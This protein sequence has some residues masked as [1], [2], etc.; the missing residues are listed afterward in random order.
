MASS[1][2]Q[3]CEAV[4]RHLFDIKY[5]GFNP[6]DNMQQSQILQSSS[7]QVSHDFPPQQQSHQL[8]L[9]HPFP[10]DSKSSVA[11]Q[12]TIIQQDSLSNIP[13]KNDIQSPISIQNSIPS[14][15]IQ[16]PNPTLQNYQ[17]QQP[18]SLVP[19]SNLGLQLK[20][21]ESNTPKLKSRKSLQIPGLSL[22][23]TRSVVGSQDILKTNR[24]GNSSII[25]SVNSTAAS[26]TLISSKS[27]KISVSPASSIQIQASKTSPLFE[28]QN[29]INARKNGSVK[30]NEQFSK[31][32]TSHCPTSSSSCG[33]LDEENHSDDSQDMGTINARS[34]GNNNNNNNGNVMCVDTFSDIPKFQ[35][36][37][38]QPPQLMYNQEPQQV[39]SILCKQEA[40]SPTASTSGKIKSFEADVMS[41]FSPQNQQ[42]KQPQQNQ[43][44][45]QYQHQ[46][47]PVEI[48]NH[49]NRSSFDGSLQVCKINGPENMWS[50]PKPNELDFTESKSAKSPNTQLGYKINNNNSNDDD[51]DSSV[52]KNGL[53]FSSNHPNSNNYSATIDHDQ[54]NNIYKEEESLEYEA[55][56]NENNKTTS[57]ED[58][59]SVCMDGS[60]IEF[61]GSSIHEIG[62]GGDNGNYKY[63]DFNQN[64][65]AKP[66][67]LPIGKMPLDISDKTIKL[68]SAATKPLPIPIQSSSPIQNSLTSEKERISG[69][70][71]EYSQI[72]VLSSSGSFHSIENEDED[73]RDS[74]ERS[75]DYNHHQDITSVG[76]VINLDS[77]D[78]DDDDGDG[79]SDDDDDDARREDFNEYIYDDGDLDLLESPN[80]GEDPKNRDSEEK[81][82]LN[83][84]R[85][86]RTHNIRGHKMN[87]QF[88]GNTNNKSDGDIDLDFYSNNSEAERNYEF[89]N[90]T[91]KNYC[92][93]NP[94][95]FPK[96]PIYNSSSSSSSQSPS[97]IA[98]SL[99]FQ[100]IR[101]S[102]RYNNNKSNINNSP[103]NISE[104]NRYYTPDNQEEMLEK[105]SFNGMEYNSPSETGVYNK[106]QMEPRSAVTVTKETATILKNN[107]TNNNNYGFNQYNN[108]VTGGGGDD[109]TNF[110]SNA[111]SSA[112]IPFSIAAAA[113]A[114]AAAAAAAAATVTATASA[115]ERRNVDSPAYE[116][117]EL[118]GRK[119]SDKIELSSNGYENNNSN[120]RNQP[121][122]SIDHILPLKRRDDDDGQMDIGLDVD[123]GIGDPGSTIGSGLEST[124]IGSC[125]NP[126]SGTVASGTSDGSVQ[127]VLR[128]VLGSWIGDSASI[129]ERVARE[130]HVLN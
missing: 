101:P 99:S 124:G 36:V 113:I 92:Y 28:S 79:D 56:N 19:I 118:S 121:L 85:S 90:N 78:D 120:H 38:P 72:D 45:N 60:E 77:D 34:G 18:K 94:Q 3:N 109:N 52:F 37:Q 61:I 117:S 87:D 81:G 66:G 20:S 75:N 39:Y 31:Y 44:Q 23:S 47:I 83:R 53:E 13:S 16:I 8:S 54:V 21:L 35:Q 57:I 105:F 50:L 123:M 84:F 67:P 111:S 15:Q 48:A 122:P 104:N 49:S 1:Y 71:S 32:K 62:T 110:R 86:V 40:N 33:I 103:P 58:N 27:S 64:Q 108:T 88:D 112:S 2:F 80:S 106:Q 22:G 63:Q 10:Y 6:F 97:S 7:S 55:I 115:E 26:S 130:G 89:N 82:S 100:S 73:M 95:S 43:N 107:N 102:E 91:Q 93:D 24:D 41:M 17:Q 126:P 69:L 129:S 30:C 128:E 5:H 14:P 74:M 42:K 29:N 98:R 59:D 119:F 76:G 51:G 70:G 12:S 68:Q 46:Q 25:N 127:K 9:P 116:N 11:Q 114:A 96:Q 4:T 125:S 65:G